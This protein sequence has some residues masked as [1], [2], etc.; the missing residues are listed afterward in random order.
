MPKRRTDASKRTFFDQYERIK[1]SYF[2]ARDVIDPAKNTALIPCANGQ[3]KLLA[4]A[5]S[6]FPSGGGYSYFRCPQCSRR[7]GVLYLVSSNMPRC[8]NCCAAM[9]IKHRSQYGFGRQERMR[10]ADLHLDQLIAKLETR[11]RLRLKPPPASWGGK[12]QHVYGSRALTERMRRRMITLRLS[13]LASQHAQATGGLN[14]TRAFTPRKDALAA[15][16]ELA[17]VWRAR[18]H[19]RLQ[20]ALDNIQCVLLRALES[21]DPR[22]RLIA[23]RLM[24]KTKQARERGF[25]T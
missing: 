13:Q 1:A 5:H 9:N 12:A 18:T 6:R 25:R 2:R 15:I 20:Q 11:E 23:A 16:P 4:V 7:A 24:L 19:E 3:T 10:A 21:S 17:Q 14:L 22:Q 8:V